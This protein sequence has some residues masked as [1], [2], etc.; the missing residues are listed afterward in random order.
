MNHGDKHWFNRPDAWWFSK[1][2]LQVSQSISH[3]C[4]SCIVASKSG[5]MSCCTLSVIKPHTKQPRKGKMLPGSWLCMT[6]P[7]KIYLGF[8]KKG[9]PQKIIPN[10]YRIFHSKPS[11]AP[12]N[13]WGPSPARFLQFDQGNEAIPSTVVRIQNME[14]G[15]TVLASLAPDWSG[16]RHLKLVACCFYPSKNYGKTHGKT[17]WKAKHII[18]DWW[19]K[20]HGVRSQSPLNHNG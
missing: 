3:S 8:P 14:D 18:L 1:N 11:P 15:L 13:S 10:F 2:I 20:T 7:V 5:R 6:L 9:L 17:G 12:S 16:P 19:V 4:L